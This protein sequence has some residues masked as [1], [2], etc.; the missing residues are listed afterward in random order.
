MSLITLKDILINAR[1]ESYRMRHF[2]LGVEHLFIALLEIKH[3]L[4]SLAM[5]EYG[6]NNDYV[7]DAIR[8]KA[9]KGSRHR[10]WAGVP[11]TPR[12]EVVFGVAQ[13]IAREDQR[14]TINERDL[15]IAIL[16]ENDSI[17]ARVLISL[18]LDIDELKKKIKTLQPTHAATGAFTKIELSPEFKGELSTDEIFIL[19][20]M[21]HGYTSIRIDLGLM[22]GYT[23]AQL[24]VVTPIRVEDR[25]AASVVVKIGPTDAILDE[26]QRY[27]KYVKDTLP[28]LTARLEDKPVAPESSELAGLKYTFLT[29]SAGNP[30][31]MR[32][33]VNDW[34]GDKL[35]RWLHSRLYGEF[36]E[37]WWKQKRP[38]R[39][40]AWREYDWLL[41]PLLT[42]KFSRDLEK[43]KGATTLRFPIRRH[44]ITSLDLGEVIAVQNFLVYKVEPERGAIRLALAQGESTARAYQIEVQGIDF[45]KDTYFRGEVVDQLVGTVWKTRDDELMASLA[46]LEPDFEVHG[47]SITI[48]GVVLPNPVKFY[49]PMLDAIIM[50]TI[51]TIHGDLHL[52]N[53]LI[54]PSDSALLIDFAR[55]RDGHAIFDWANLE[56]SLLSELVIPRI[57]NT[58]DDARKLLGYLAAVDQP[59][60]AG[61]VPE[62]IMDALKAI[63]ALRQIVAQTLAAEGVW[64]E[65]S[66]TLA[67]AALRA[68][69]WQ[70]LPIE[71][72]R[73]MYLVSAFAMFHFN[74]REH[75]Q[76]SDADGTPSPERTEAE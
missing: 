20:R 75:G 10:L 19:R 42:L 30:T 6:L 17:P 1:Q 31:D 52:G 21:F 44:K 68:M 65:Y 67:F 11:N 5:N 18:E 59:E 34:S 53:I 41:P 74:H 76:G 56:V 61:G 57:G 32:A 13:E 36:G 60:L 63:T 71:S 40:E 28:P 54:G 72:R 70:T 9:G 38:Y 25:P 37:K 33:K 3:G 16:E 66:L 48:N 51:S 69:T 58:W 14:T 46:E 49:T 73:V 29:D 24:L 12:T 22:G 27:N 23:T 39:F 15:I 43:P 50:G 8:R 7:I 4:A 55:T 35:G 47:N 62:N 64:H 26:A 45:E 2:F